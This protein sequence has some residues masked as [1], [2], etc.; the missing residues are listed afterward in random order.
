MIHQIIKFIKVRQMLE[1]KVKSI[2]DWHQI[3]NDLDQDGVKYMPKIWYDAEV[4]FDN[5][6]YE[7]V[8]KEERK[9]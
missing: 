1:G 7:I 3:L 8:V 9:K 2:I 5:Y 6:Q 4:D